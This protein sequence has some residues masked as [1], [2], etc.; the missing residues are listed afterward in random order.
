M[1]NCTEEEI[2]DALATVIEEV[3]TASVVIT[4]KKFSEAKADLLRLLA[5]G[6]KGKLLTDNHCAR[7]I[8][9]SF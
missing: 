6:A 9:F 2:F 8:L 5:S 1:V 4:D 7:S 3:S